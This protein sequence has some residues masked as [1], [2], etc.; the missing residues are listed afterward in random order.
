MPKY[1]D[2]QRIIKEHARLLLMLAFSICSYMPL[3]SQRFHSS[4]DITCLSVQPNPFKDISKEFTLQLKLTNRSHDS[5]RVDDT[6]R[7]QGYLNYQFYYISRYVLAQ[8]LPKDSSC[9]LYI[10]GQYNDKGFE[11][12][13]IILLC[14][15]SLINKVD[16][17][18]HKAYEVLLY[19]GK[20]FPVILQPEPHDSKLD[21]DDYPS[22]NEIRFRYYSSSHGS[23][24]WTLTGNMGRQL[25]HGF[26]D[27]TVGENPYTIFIE[28]LPAGKYTLTIGNGSDAEYDTFTVIG[29]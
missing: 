21:V 7:I 5:L 10:T 29:R 2:S 4:V 20:H 14:G 19:L 3:I 11:Q 23:F 16:T 15:M 18:V 27:V 25:L 8:T 22:G 26:L 1:L 17:N 13:Q 24:N 28:N 6:I 12:S 9:R